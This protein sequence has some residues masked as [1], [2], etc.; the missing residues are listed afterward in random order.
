MYCQSDALLGSKTHPAYSCYSILSNACMV[1]TLGGSTAMILVILTI[2]PWF[3]VHV[4]YRLPL[5]KPSVLPTVKNYFSSYVDI[6]HIVDTTHTTH[7][8]RP[9]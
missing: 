3:C 2:L 5:N 9:V 7:L 8:V 4:K 1:V 6:L